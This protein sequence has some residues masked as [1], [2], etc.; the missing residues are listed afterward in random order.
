M[1]ESKNGKK[2]GRPTV[3]KY[4]KK[5]YRYASIEKRLLDA[6]EKMESEHDKNI[7]RSVLKSM[8]EN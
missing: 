1:T 6:I 2:M 7:V 4:R 3:P 5:Q 8:Q